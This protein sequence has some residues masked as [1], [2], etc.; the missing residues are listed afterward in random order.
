M[1]LARVAR[2]VAAAS[3]LVSLVLGALAYASFRAALAARLDRARSRQAEVIRP[4]A[5]A[6]LEAALAEKRLALVGEK[7]SQA[8]AAA[9]RRTDA[10]RLL[11]TCRVAGVDAALLE[12]A[13]KALAENKPPG[14]EGDI[15]MLRAIRG[16]RLEAAKL[17]APARPEE[18]EEARTAGRLLLAAAASACLAVLFG[19]AAEPATR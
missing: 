15:A 17:P 18:P 7:E 2:I 9:L 19:R 3:L 6:R 11:E 16:L 1:A 12:E 4:A 14:P 13:Q 5:A 8:V 10:A